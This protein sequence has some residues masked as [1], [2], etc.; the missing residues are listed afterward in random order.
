MQYKVSRDTKVAAVGINVCTGRKWSAPRELQVIWVRQKVLVGMVA[1]GQSGLD[2]F[3]SCQIGKAKGKEQPH[4][5]QGGVSGGVETNYQVR[6]T[7]THRAKMRHLPALCVLGE[8]PFNISSAA[9]LKPWPMSITAG[10]MTSCSW[11]L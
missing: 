1:T 8:Y 11:Q 5:L 6:Q 9:A 10:A 4:L 7:F 3:P 2:Y